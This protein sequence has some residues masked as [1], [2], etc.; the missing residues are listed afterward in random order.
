MSPSEKLTEVEEKT[1]YIEGIGSSEVAWLI[2]RV[3]TLEKFI[4]KFNEVVGDKELYVSPQFPME[5]LKLHL[6]SD[7]ILGN[8]SEE[9]THE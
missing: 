4:K 6:E 8:Y 2:V 7:L 1:Q 5:L 3:K 9:I